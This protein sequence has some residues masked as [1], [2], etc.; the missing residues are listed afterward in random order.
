MK[1]ALDVING[2]R[3]RCNR[4][5][6]LLKQTQSRCNDKEIKVGARF[7]RW[8]V[9]LEVPERGY[10]GM[11][12]Y[13]CRCDCGTVK[14]VYGASLRNGKSKSCGC[15]RGSKLKDGRLT[16]PPRTP[17]NNTSGHVGVW[18]NKSAN[19]WVARIKVSGKQIYLGKFK[20]YE[21]AVKARELAEEQYYGKRSSN[22]ND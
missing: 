15:G 3:L 13:E 11:K 20:E 2:L 14:V 17:K 18:W 6:E 7:G 22:G 10:H 4:L 19:R 8:T 1:D 12:R 5:E 16:N 21:D 9:L